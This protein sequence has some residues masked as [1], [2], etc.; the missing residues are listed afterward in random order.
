MGEGRA[1][2]IFLCGHPAE[3]ALSTP[4][5]HWFLIARVLELLT[6]HQGPTEAFGSPTHTPAEGSLP[7][8]AGSGHWC[9]PLLLQPPLP[10]GSGPHQTREIQEEF[11]SASVHRDLQPSV[12]TCCAASPSP[13]ASRDIFQP[14]GK[15]APSTAAAEGELSGISCARKCCQPLSSSPTFP[16]GGGL[17][18]SQQLRGGGLFRK[19]Y[20]LP[21][22]KPPKAPAASAS[23]H[24]FCF[25]LSAGTREAG[26]PGSHNANAKPIHSRGSASAGPT[27][28]G[29]GWSRAPGVAGHPPG[30][31]S[32]PGH[33]E[34]RAGP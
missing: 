20:N 34:R 6:Q 8:R 21:T 13:G 18:L 14:N 3:P 24:E 33:A 16:S 23:V 11:Q 26:G 19:P 1:I 5:P 27:D 7:S 17:L 15:T 30:P 4:P 2:K 12:S 32:G 10:R 28:P 31:K 22:P 9:C 25:L 29:S